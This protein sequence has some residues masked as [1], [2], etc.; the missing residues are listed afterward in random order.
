[1]KT[2]FRLFLTVSILIATPQVQLLNAG[3][4]SVD[5]YEQ[6][7]DA[8]REVVH[9]KGRFVELDI[10]LYIAQSITVDV[11]NECD[12]IEF[13]HNPRLSPD[14]SMVFVGYFLN[15]EPGELHIIYLRQATLGAKISVRNDTIENFSKYTYKHYKTKFFYVDKMDYNSLGSEELEH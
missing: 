8:I 1:M 4:R 9:Q 3:V 13:M 6:S 15:D 10:P 2:I 14:Q 5:G 7:Y 12:Q 11:M